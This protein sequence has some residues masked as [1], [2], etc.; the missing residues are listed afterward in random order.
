MIVAQFFQLRTYFSLFFRV[1][2]HIRSL[3]AWTFRV[4]KRDGLSAIDIYTE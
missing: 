3:H 4:E 2:E 1:V